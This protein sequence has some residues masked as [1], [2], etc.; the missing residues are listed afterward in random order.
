MTTAASPRLITAL[1][2]AGRDRMMQLSHEAH[3]PRGAR[4]CEEGR[5]SDRFWIVRTGSVTLDLHVPGRRAAQVAT[6]GPNDLLGWSW[7]FPPHTW[8][9][10]ATAL[11]PVRA[12][13]FDGD[14]VRQLCEEEP[15]FGQALTRCVAEIIA[16]RLHAARTRLLDLY[17]PQGSGPRL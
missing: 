2:P 3:F 14:A 11:S 17:G 4:I 9:L 5:R 6:L 7:L 16:R 10:G 12:L 1:P 15:V 13:E 8:Q